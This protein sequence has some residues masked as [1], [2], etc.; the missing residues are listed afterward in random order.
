MIGD[1]TISDQKIK[2]HR[3]SGDG[4]PPGGVVCLCVR[5]EDHDE[6][7]FDVPLGGSS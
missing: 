1:R 5:G 3:C 6:S 2:P 7:L 4:Y